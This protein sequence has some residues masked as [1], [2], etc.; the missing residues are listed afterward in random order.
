MAEV[1]WTFDVGGISV[2]LVGPPVWVEPFARAWTSWAGKE[3]GW[4]VRLAQDA[5]LPLPR[6]PFFA[7]RPCFAGDRCLLEAPGFVGEIAPQEGHAL[8]RAHP[9]A[10][11]GDLAY[12]IRTAFAL[13][14]FDR[15]AL[16][17]H[18]AGIVHRTAAYAFFGRSGS[19]KTTVARL[20]AGKPVLSDDLLLLRPAGTIWEA[21]ATPFGRRRAPEVRSAPLRALLC[22]VQ[23]PEARLE[24]M[25]QGAA[26][27][28]LV[29]NS[30]V[31]NADLRRVARLLGRWEAI[32]RAAPAH[33]L[34]FRK[35]A[36]FWEV[37]DA[38]FG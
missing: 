11:P 23:S 17:F 14:A 13:R 7:A 19:G 16:L 4:K 21:W 33:F 27:G 25:S 24:P 36:T 20:S 15:G 31:V 18:A 28:E 5:T 1:S 3:S 10:E 38:H 8:L 6:G 9:T 32:L 12:F 22:L 30:P 37:I 29:A 26:L 34:H 2:T 35:S